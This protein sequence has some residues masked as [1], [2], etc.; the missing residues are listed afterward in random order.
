M[1]ILSHTAVFLMVLHFLEIAIWATVYLLIPELD[2][3]STW[4][5][6]IYFSMVTFTT[7]GYGDLTLPPIWRIMSGFEAMNGILMFGW[8]TAMFYA[9]VQKIITLSNQKQ[10]SD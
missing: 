4:E 5:E 6:A 7:L 9:V 8:S 10:V 3:L 1:R 2:K